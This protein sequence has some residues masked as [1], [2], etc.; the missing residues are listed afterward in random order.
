MG[1]LACKRMIGS[2]TYDVLAD[3]ITDQLDKYEIRKKCVAVITDNGCNF[4]KAFRLA[5]LQ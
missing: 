4:V 5:I 3:T 2:I 1:V